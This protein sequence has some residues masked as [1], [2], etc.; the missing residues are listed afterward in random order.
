MNLEVTESIM[1][2]DTTQVIAQLIKL[3]SKGVGIA[4]DDFGSGYASLNTC[5]YLPLTEIKIDRQIMVQALENPLILSFLKSV[6]QLFH[7]HN[8]SI[9][10]EGIENQDL[11]KYF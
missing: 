5:I 4:L 10:A 6:T 3:K 7:D 1:I 2:N 8:M 9:V 11:I